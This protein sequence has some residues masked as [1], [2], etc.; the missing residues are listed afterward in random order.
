MRR[1]VFGRFFGHR[2]FGSRYFGGSGNEVV[3]PP[4]VA[5]TA[6]GL[7]WWWRAYL[8]QRGEPVT[9]RGV[10]LVLYVDFEPGEATGSAKTRA[11]RL[12][13]K[14]DIDGGMPR[15]PAVAGLGS[16][17]ISV[18]MFG[19]EFALSN[20]FDPGSVRANA[21]TLPADLFL[22]PVMRV[23]EARSGASVAGI[24]FAVTIKP[25][26]ATAR[27]AASIAGVEIERGAVASF[28]RSTGAADVVGLPIE[29]M[30]RISA[31]A[32]TGKT[33]FDTAKLDNDLLM[34]AA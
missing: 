12:K 15:A 19:H 7:P 28:G 27:A 16:A 18:E 17:S 9:V 13:A 34:I 29:I 30:A 20:S 1:K 3:Q 31:G 23:G 24:G 22:S 10:D 2:Y 4:V 8:N 14:L 21:V 32:A 11:R 5:E 25:A 6:S 33:A 26:F